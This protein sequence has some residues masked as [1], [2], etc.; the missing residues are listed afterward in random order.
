[1][2]AFGKCKAP[3]RYEAVKV[4][5]KKHSNNKRNE[6]KCSRLGSD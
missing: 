3:F 2:T 4:I 6:L 1:M 5:G